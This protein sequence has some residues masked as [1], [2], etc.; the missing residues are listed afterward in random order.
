MRPNENSIAMDMK[1][2]VLRYTITD[3]GCWVHINK[4]FK[5]KYIYLTHGHSD[6]YLAHRLSYI[7]HKGSIPERMTILHSCD[8][9]PC[10][11][12][13]H[14]SIGTQK[15]NLADMT[16]KGRRNKLSE[17]DAAFIITLRRRGL[18]Q[19]RVA[20]ILGVHQSTVSDYERR[21]N[22]K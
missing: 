8:N 6:K 13:D 4:P 1:S 9:P 3:S 17:D 10:I 18:S 16:S 21:A 15:E 20:E 2:L 12:P 11:N 22:E 5:N 19:M 14:L 7:I